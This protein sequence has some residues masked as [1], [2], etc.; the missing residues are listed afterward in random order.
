MAQVFL[1]RIRNSS[2]ISISGDLDLGL[3]KR[4]GISHKEGWQHYR[5]NS[6]GRNIGRPRLGFGYKIRYGGA[7]RKPGLQTHLNA[8][9]GRKV[10]S[11]QAQTTDHHRYYPS[12]AEFPK[13][14]IRYPQTRSIIFSD[15]N[16]TFKRVR[17][18]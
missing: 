10:E 13:K 3:V 5:Q 11:P 7:S 4:Y 14:A 8:V 1:N 16:T 18:T 2:T 6:T 9:P 17:D 12:P 15:W